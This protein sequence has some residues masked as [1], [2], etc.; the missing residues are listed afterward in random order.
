MSIKKYLLLM[1]FIDL[2][3][4]QLSNKTFPL[5]V[6]DFYGHNQKVHN[7]SHL[8]HGRIKA[9]R[10]FAC[11]PVCVVCQIKWK[12]RKPRSVPGVSSH[13]KAPLGVAGGVEKTVDTEA[14]AC[15]CPQ[16]QASPKQMPRIL[17]GS[18]SRLGIASGLPRGARCQVMQ[19]GRG[20]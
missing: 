7:F 14:G 4:R 5:W 11:C 6:V 16:A 20:R 9:E 10:I 3:V 13:T 19:T 18:F 8:T 1:F 15:Y 2:L 17:L 12:G